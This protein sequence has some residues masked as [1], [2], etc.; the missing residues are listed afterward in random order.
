[1]HDKKRPTYGTGSEKDEPLLV[2]GMVRIG[3][4]QSTRIIEDALRLLKPNSV[5]PPI[6]PVLPLVPFE[7]KLI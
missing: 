6:G 2:F 4:E 1:M 7:A 3:K 5:L